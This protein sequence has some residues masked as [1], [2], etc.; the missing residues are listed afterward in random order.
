MHAVMI[1][2]GS[3]TEHYERKLP[4]KIIDVAPTIAKLLN[5][6]VPKSAEGG[7]LYDILD[8]IHKKG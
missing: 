1:L 7:V 4:A 5:I 8:R 3:G 6:K 2:A